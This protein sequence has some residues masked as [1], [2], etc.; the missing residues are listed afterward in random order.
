M[1]IP[2][3]PGSSQVAKVKKMYKEKHKIQGGDVN[4]GGKHTHTER[5]I[6]R[7]SQR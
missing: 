6:V 1:S 7:D 5:E 4:V 2:S 3:F